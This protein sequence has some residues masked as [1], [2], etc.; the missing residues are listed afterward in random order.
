MITNIFYIPAKG[1]EPVSCTSIKLLVNLGMDNDY[2]ATGG[3][4]QLLIITNKLYELLRKDDGLCFKRFKANIVV[5]DILQ[6]G[7]YTIGDSVIQVK[8]HQKKCFEEC[9]KED[10]SN[11]LMKYE[12]YDACVISTGNIKIGDEVIKKS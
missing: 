12:V 1:E 11:C 7:E 5:E 9:L 10:K 6:D 4:K 8:K 3:D 2:H